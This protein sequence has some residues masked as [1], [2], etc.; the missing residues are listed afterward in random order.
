MPKAYAQRNDVPEEFTW[1]L[2]DLYP[3]EEDWEA[4]AEDL[5]SESSR[6]AAMQG[7]LGS[8]AQALL[9]YFLLE[10]ALSDRLHRLFTYAGCRADQNTGDGRGQELRSRASTVAVALDSAGA[11]IAPEIMAIPDETLDRFYRECPALETYRRPLYRLR[12]RKEH[13][14][15]PE[16]E[17]LLAAAGEMGDAPDNIFSIFTGADLTFPDVVDGAGERRHLT[18]GS[19][20]PMLESP[21]PAFRQRVFETYYKQLGQ[22]RNTAAAVLDAQ[23]KQL[24]FFSRARKYASTRQASL[25]RNEVPET[26]YDALIEAVHGNLDK[27]Y[28]YVALRKKLLGAETLHMWDVYTPIVADAAVTIPYDQAKATVLEALGVLGED[29]TDIL[30]QGFENRWI[31]VYE[32]AGKRSGAYSTGS[33]EPHPYVLL[34]QQDTLDSMFTLAH[35]M[36][37]ALHSYYSSKHQP[38]CTAGYVIFVAEVA[39]TC[40]EMLLMHHLLGKTDDIKQRAYLINHFLDEFKGT[41]YRQTMFAEF[42]REIGSLAENGQALTADTLSTLY[43]DL[44]ALYYGPDMA[45]DPGIVLEWARIPHFYYN[46]YVFQYATGFSAAVAIADRILKEGAPAVADYKRFLSAGSSTDPISLLKIAGVDMST[47]VP[48]NEALAYFGDLVKE[49]EDLTA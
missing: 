40:N 3:S 14:L 35:E 22:F 4:E 5:L 1:N 39:S 26:V 34:N 42:E 33:G 21:D 18:N 29:Y 28:R 2:R 7:T 38:T 43:G 10:D 32:S 37:H 6:I 23:F 9:D 47:P 31:D 12:R 19:F 15:S 46:Y 30:R 27:M 24:L 8:S 36:G 20:V 45:R 13:I 16:C 44:N 48:V 49:L 25:D 17:Q 41:I 11:F